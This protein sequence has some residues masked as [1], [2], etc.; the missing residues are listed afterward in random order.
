MAWAWAM[1]HG[2]DDVF[3]GFG[4]ERG[5]EVLDVVELVADVASFSASATEQC[6]S[7]SK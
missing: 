5:K 3:G 4:G 6:R 2:F 7:T 1:D